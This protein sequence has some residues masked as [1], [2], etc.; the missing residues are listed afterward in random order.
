[1]RPVALRLPHAARL[2]RSPR[3][4]ATAAALAGAVALA[5]PATAQKT[6]NVGALPQGSLS[7][8]IGATVAKAIGDNT[9]LKTRAI[10]FGGSNIYIPMPVVNSSLPWASM[11]M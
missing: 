3:I 1:M 4:T 7:Y 8:A 11:G 9:D 10:G 5:A 6:L 2:A